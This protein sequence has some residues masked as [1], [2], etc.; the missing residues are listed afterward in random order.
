MSQTD[1]MNGNKPILM[2]ILNVTPDSFSD[3]GCFFTPDKAVSRGRELAEQGADVIDV[4]GESTRPGSHFVD[5]NEE[6]RRVLPVIE[7]LAQ[8]DGLYVSVDTTKPGVAYEALKLGAKM[9]NDVSNLRDGS[10]L[11]SV[12]AQWDAELVLMH[13]R[14]T[15]MNMSQLTN[16]K[17]VVKEVSDE[18]MESVSRALT[19][20]VDRKRIWLDP[21]I[22]FAKD[23][24]QSIEL[25]SRLD[26]L[27]SLGYPVL[28]GPSRKSFI[29]GFDGSE[30]NDRLGGT[31]AAVT[32]AVFKGAR[33]LRVHDV[34]QMHQAMS[35]AYAIAKERHRTME[36]SSENA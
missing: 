6:K 35:I 2:G 8:K 24:V 36:E 33:A 21:G 16:Y 19:A 31:A 1:F 27:V 28:V 26:E 13:T 7:E 4:G 15:P 11:A 23:A 5:E 25:L 22:G 18:L 9:I 14:G 29:G 12:A 3:G 20:G 30:E 32:A 10:E 17:D 34:R